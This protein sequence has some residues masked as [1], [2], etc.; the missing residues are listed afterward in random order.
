MD[1]WS[2]DHVD[3]AIAK[4]STLKILELQLC[5]CNRVLCSNTLKHRSL[6]NN[7]DLVIVCA[8]VSL[9]DDLLFILQSKTNSFTCRHP[10]CAVA[11]FPLATV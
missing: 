10:S 8:T 1:S 9:N 11:S 7:S 3:I 5:Q 6:S 2:E 4:N